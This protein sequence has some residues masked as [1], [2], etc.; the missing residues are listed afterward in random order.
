M[1]SI[2]RHL[3]TAPRLELANSALLKVGGIKKMRY[4]NEWI[5]RADISNNPLHAPGQHLSKMAQATLEP[6]EVFFEN[7][8]RAVISAAAAWALLVESAFNM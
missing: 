2:G 3:A 7:G 5:T 8:E 4:R 1:S 6:V